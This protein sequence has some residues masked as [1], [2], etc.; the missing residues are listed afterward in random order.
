[1]SKLKISIYVVLLNMTALYLLE[2]GA[3]YVVVYCLLFCLTVM[4][5]G[6]L[7]NRCG[8]KFSSQ[9]I[10]HYPGLYEKYK[11]KP[12]HIPYVDT[13]ERLSI[14]KPK[15]ARDKEAMSKLNQYQKKL[16]TI[17]MNSIY[18]AILSL[19]LLFPNFILSP[20]FIDVKV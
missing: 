17:Y 2:I 16:L 1:M 4:F 18:G 12:P 8:K 14:V 3:H 9:L 19:V 11:I 7:V 5:F 6:I 10:E 20:L 13:T 15:F